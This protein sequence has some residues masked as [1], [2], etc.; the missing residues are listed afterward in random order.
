MPLAVSLTIWSWSINLLVGG[1]GNLFVIG[2]GL[3]LGLGV[4]V[5][6]ASS[7]IR[8]NIKVPHRS[9]TFQS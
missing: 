5:Y 2:N 8:F 1:L 7:A 6:V 9:L 4:V 3:L